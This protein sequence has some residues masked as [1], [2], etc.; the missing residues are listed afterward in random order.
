M[1]MQH[2]KTLL[3]GVVALIT[4]VMCVQSVFTLSEYRKRKLMHSTIQIM[5]DQALFANTNAPFKTVA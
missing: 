4:V 1:N 5:L 2:N 3:R